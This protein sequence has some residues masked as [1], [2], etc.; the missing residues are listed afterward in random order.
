[1]GSPSGVD[2]P[3]SNLQKLLNNLNQNNNNNNQQQQQQQ[4]SQSTGNPILDLLN[5]ASNKDQS[6]N[7]NLDTDSLVHLGK[8]LMERMQKKEDSL[9]LTDSISQ[10]FSALTKSST[11]NNTLFNALNSNAQQNNTTDLLNSLMA[12]TQN[13]Q[14]NNLLGSF[15]NLANANLNFN[16]Q[17]LNLNGN[18]NLNNQPNRNNLVG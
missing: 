9:S 2:S 4:Q 1:M 18:N 17:N 7:T 13:S 11:T 8:S 10:Q 3:S 12:Q 6:K 15:P 16:P 5:N 14:N